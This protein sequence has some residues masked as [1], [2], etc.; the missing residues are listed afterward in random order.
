MRGGQGHR[1]PGRSQ[2]QG[3]EG[4]KKYDVKG[5]ARGRGQTDEV[6][7]NR[8][9]KEQHKPSRGRRQAADRKRMGFG[10]PPPK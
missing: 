2:P 1:Q 5:R 4:E 6:L 10:A 3:Q 7:R 9:W 8:R